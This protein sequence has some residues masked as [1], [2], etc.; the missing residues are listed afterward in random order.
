MMNGLSSTTVG[1]Y[2]TASDAATLQ[3]YGAAASLGCIGIFAAVVGLLHL[4]KPE[5][6]PSWRFL[7]E[8]SIGRHGWLMTAAFF[9]W[10][11][12]CAALVT[13]LGG[14]LATR[15]GRIGNAALAI[16]AVSLVAAGLFDQDPVTAKPDELTTH[17]TLHA[18]ASMIGIPG[19]PFA[20]L[21]IS[22]SL[23]RYNTAWAPW[24]RSLMATAHLT[25]LCLL[26]MVVYLAI[27]VP[28]AGG[29]GPDVLSGWMNRAVVAAYCAWQ[30]AAG[31]IAY[32][33]IGKGGHREAAG[34]RRQRSRHSNVS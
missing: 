2:A 18:V 26:A 22:W 13:A 11:L 16:V 24:R 25:W 8:Y 1:Q 34:A 19:I 9:T 7:S 3:R 12:S 4:I 10:A 29:F 28:Q 6:D 15:A 23:T 30:L 5:F 17:G 32:R 27:A 21:L 14:Q 33:V 20:A 31:Y